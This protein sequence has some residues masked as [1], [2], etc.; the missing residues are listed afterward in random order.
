MTRLSL[1]ILPLCLAVS[2]A[3]AGPLDRFDSVHVFGDSYSDGGNLMTAL[4]GAIPGIPLAGTIYPRLQ[5]TNGD[6]WST[7]LGL[8]PSLLGGT[9]H[10][11]GGAEA[12]AEA[13]D[14]GGVPDLA[15][16]IASLPG[17]TDL[18]GTQ[19]LALVFL[20]GNDLREALVSQDAQ[21]LS[22]TIG[23]TVGALAS[24]TGTLLGLGF[25]RVLVAGVFDFG[26][27]PGIVGTAA[28]PLA[29][30]AS[31]GFNTALGATLAGSFAGQQVAYLDVA[32]MFD[33][34]RGDPAS[35]GLTNLTEPCL[36]R[37][38]ADTASHDACLLA[39]P[40]QYLF[41]DDIHIT[42]SVQGVVAAGVV[43]AVPL[44]PGGWLL[45]GGL[46]LLGV[47]RGLRGRLRSVVC[48]NRG[49]FPAR[50]G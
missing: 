13:A 16:Q 5:F 21:V 10:A 14:A 45:A 7:Q 34:V 8:V 39:D 15:G 28:A 4:N 31:L 46:A 49:S 47:G 48:R 9:N 50:P 43:A 20:G 11:W 40:A 1:L 29:T 30:Q 3:A 33:A 37:R 23:A 41:Y 26:A 35:L 22:D 2:G 24:G 17:G 38:S 36:D 44:P 25:D 12:L 42:E 32:A 27:F 18:S 19:D 6:V